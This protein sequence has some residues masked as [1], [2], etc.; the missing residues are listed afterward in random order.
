[1][2]PSTDA[3]LGSKAARGPAQSGT[4]ARRPDVRFTPPFGL[5][6]MNGPMA[7]MAELASE[8]FRRHPAEVRK[9]GPRAVF[10]SDVERVILCAP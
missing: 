3:M 4:F 2:P 9:R 1:M 10:K 7:V 8:D 6:G 5:T